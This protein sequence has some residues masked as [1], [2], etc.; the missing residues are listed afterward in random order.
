M[1][2]CKGTNCR[3]CSA[4]LSGGS[5]LGLTLAG[6]VTPQTHGVDGNPVVLNQQTY[7]TSTMK[8][9]RA[10]F[11]GLTC[12]VILL[13]APPAATAV[14]LTTTYAFNEVDG[15][16]VNG[17]V[18]GSD[19]NFYGTTG[20]GGPVWPE[21]WGTIFRVA[22]DGTLTT[23]YSFSGPDGASPQ[24]TLIQG[25]DGSFYGATS[26]GGPAFNAAVGFAGGGT[27]FKM[28]P[29]GTLTTPVSFDGVTNGSPSLF[30][31]ASDGN[32]YGALGR[33]NSGY[34]GTL[35]KITPDGT[36]TTVAS[37][38]GTNGSGPSS[39]I[40]ARDGNFYGTTSSGGAYTNR[41][42]PDGFGTIFR[43]TAD[44]S[45]RTLASFSFTNGAAP[46]SLMQAS[47]GDFY[48]TTDNGGKHTVVTGAS[49]GTYDGYPG[50][51]FR[52]TASGTITAM[53]L[54]NGANGWGPRAGMV[55]GTDGNFYGSTFEGGPPG[56]SFTW[57]ADPYGLGTLFKMTPQGKL[58]TLSLF[59]GWN[60]AYPAASLVQLSDGSFY[61]TTTQGGN[62]NA[63][64]NPGGAGTIFRVSVPGASS[65]KIVGTTQSGSQLNLTWLALTG[66]SYQLQSSTDLLE[67]NWNTSG[68]AVSATNSMATA[69]EAMASGPQRFYRVVLLP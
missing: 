56:P 2:T 40:Q 35:F 13:L 33:A 31:Q 24:G 68:G 51:I 11:T 47:D 58:T 15:S 57:F 62:T 8:I 64:G 18:L 46:N 44:G 39:L 19:G 50:T 69:S 4:F 61:G 7:P 14:T 36:L 3:G 16:F 26:A 60:Y 25:A 30:L 66:R 54:F 65:P 10:A 53:V 22:L 42:Y 59:N 6:R 32:F 5:S 29:D 9:L 17:L 63:P 21:V 12:S 67:T 45:L 34:S 28:T 52:V 1:T 23:L 37:F 20:G 43:L 55:E 41:D 38:Y 48:G 27:I 49:G